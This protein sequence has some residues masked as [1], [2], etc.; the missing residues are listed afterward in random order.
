MEK[1][2]KDTL[3]LPFTEMPMKAGLVSI[4]PDILKKWEENEIYKKRL[5]LNKNNKTFILHDGPPYPNGNIHLGHALNKILKDI[6]VKY[7]LMK[8]EYTPFIPGWDCHG[9][10]IETQMLKE[11]KKD[12]D[13]SSEKKTTDSEVE[14]RNQCKEY[15]LRYVELQKTQFLKMGIFGD[16]NNPYLTLTPEYEKGVIE[17]FGKMAEKDVIYQ[18]RK[19]IHWCMSCTTA[20]AEAEIEY[21]DE[22]SPSIYVKFSLEK[23]FNGYNDVSFIVWTTTPWTLPANVGV[24][25]NPLFEY[26]LFEVNNEKF[27]CVENLL[28]KIKITMEWEN[29][30]VISKIKGEELVGLKYK[31]PF[32]ERVSPVI[33]AEFVSNEDGTGLVHIA[34]GHGYDDYI[35]GLK[36]NLPVVMPVDDK[37][38][39]TEEAGKYQGMKVFDANKVIVNDMEA[40]GKLL[41]MQW[42]KHSYP[43]CWRCQSPVIF[44]ATEQWFVEMDGTYDLRGKALKQIAEINKNDGW[45]PS[46]GEKRIRGMVEGRP[47]W[48]ISRQRTWGI[49]IPVFYCEKCKEPHFKGE[50][51]KAVA[52]IVGREGTNSWFIRSTEEILPK[53]VKCSK[54]GNK[55]FYKDT[56]IMDV[57]LESGA[58]HEAVIRTK[59]ELEYPADL[60][61]EGS[62]QHRGWFQSSLLTAV[63]V[64]DKAPYKQVLTHGFTIDEKGQK[65]SKSKG[66]VIDPLKV[67]SEHGVDILRLW[68]SS[69]DFRN[70]VALSQNIISQIKDAFSKI[71]NTLRF[72]ISNL[73]DFEPEKDSVAEQDL[74]LID[75]HILTQFGEMA[76]TVNNY[77]KDYF[78]HVIYRKVYDFCVSDLSAYYLDVQKDNLYCNAKSAKE[79]KSCQTAMYIMSFELVKMLAPILSFSMEDVYK[80]LPVNHKASVFMEPLSVVKLSKSNS[81]VTQMNDDILPIRS[82]INLELEKLR[83]EKVIG[84]SLD[85]KVILYTEKDIVAEDILGV[86]VVSQVEVKKVKGQDKVEVFKADGEKCER[87]WKYATLSKGGLCPRC[88]KVVNG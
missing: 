63:A 6:V 46:W 39:F 12:K 41:K 26:V 71:R 18:G 16:F 33:S 1:T 3:N 60:Y 47:D 4:E 74:C 30:K 31:H 83:K 69:T 13:F 85:A 80:Y 48:C 54:C 78:F 2:Y 40:S 49:P 17:L 87:C 79:R 38:V 67:V 23:S 45:I 8:G 75:V 65:M 84:S 86:M 44:R 53:G 73:Y 59:K 24:A 81:K 11:L 5:E 50:F 10:P 76:D 61:L 64:Y 62:D 22:K 37:G 25:V 57:W 56:N 68:V 43:H 36:F 51:N 28:E 19:P 77:Y 72:M 20:L 58:S 32:I 7:H 66:N 42:M 21:A 9:L 55:T 88:E 27:I 70:D 34:P 35:A 15:A 82:L 14:F 52:E 29:V